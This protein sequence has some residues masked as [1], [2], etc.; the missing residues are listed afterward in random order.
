[1]TAE[2]RAETVVHRICPICEACC[3]LELKIEHGK[4]AH[5][6]G[7]DADV[8]SKGYVCPKGAAL[9]DLHEDPDRLRTPLVRRDGRLIE[10]SWDEAFAEIERRLPPIAA[11]RGRD[12]VALVIGNPVVHKAGLLLYLPRLMKALGTQNFFSAS[13]LDQMPKQLSC[14]L[15]FGHWISIPVPDIERTDFLLMLGATRPC[16]TAAFGPCRTSAARPRRCAPAVAS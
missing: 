9:K 11:T 8:F 10:V 12:A 14:G 16:R 1:M 4:V 2:T 3:G 7:H 5:I 6:R 13:T 15:M